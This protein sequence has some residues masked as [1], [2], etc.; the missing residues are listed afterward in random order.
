[1]TYLLNENASA[2]KRKTKTKEQKTNKQRKTVPCFQS[3]VRGRLMQVKGQ[4]ETLKT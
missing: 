4:A 3:I 2:D 1:M